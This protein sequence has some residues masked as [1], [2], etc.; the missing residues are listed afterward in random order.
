MEYFPSLPTFNETS[1]FVGR[2]Q[3]MYNASGYCYFAADHLE[4]GRLLGFIGLCYQEY[5]SPFTPCVDIGWRLHKDFWGM[6]LATEG[7]LKNLEYAFNSL[8]LNRVR[9]FAPEINLK[10]IHVMQKI[11]M[12]FLGIFEH[13]YLKEFPLLLNC[14]CYETTKSDYF[15]D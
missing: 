4:S 2:M 14:V 12:Q 13:P 15:T 3:D 1:A 9:A 8:G 5:Q 7:A 11:G 10:S 6:G